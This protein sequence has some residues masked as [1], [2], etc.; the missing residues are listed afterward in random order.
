MKEQ[1]LFD[2]G[3]TKIE[4][5]GEEG[6]EDFYYY[7]CEISEDCDLISCSQDEVQNGRWFVEFG[8]NLEFRFYSKREVETLI[9]V[10]K[11]NIYEQ[12]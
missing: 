3:F 10:L 1:D 8:N 4:V 7:E 6:E 9:N 2:L 5:I 11:K 12:S